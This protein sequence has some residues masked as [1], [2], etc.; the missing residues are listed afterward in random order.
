[1]IKLGGKRGVGHVARVEETRNANRSL[2]RKSIG[3]DHIEHVGVAGRVI[4]KWIIQKYD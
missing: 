3:R 2:L 1:M 4:L